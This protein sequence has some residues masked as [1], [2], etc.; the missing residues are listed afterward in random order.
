[1]KGLIE[2]EIWKHQ[3]PDRAWEIRSKIDAFRRSLI[4]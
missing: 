2:L 4:L 1:M 3:A